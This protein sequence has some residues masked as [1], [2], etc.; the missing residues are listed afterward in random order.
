MRCSAS[1]FQFNLY[2]APDGYSNKITTVDAASWTHVAYVWPVGSGP[3]I[4]YN[5]AYSTDAN[6]INSASAVNT[7]RR[8]TLGRPWPTSP[9]TEAFGAVDD[10]KIYNNPLDAAAIQELY[11]SYF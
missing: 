3:L 8:I 2:V 4:Y 10:V 6:L 1:G 9:D 5:G 11:N 7:D